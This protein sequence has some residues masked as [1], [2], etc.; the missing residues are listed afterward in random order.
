MP[1]LS[2][3]TAR[4]IK[5]ATGVALMMLTRGE[6]NSEKPLKN[7]ET[8]PVRTPASVPVT[9]PTEILITE[10]KTD[11]QNSSV[12]AN[13]Q[14]SETVSTGDGRIAESPTMADNACHMP[15]HISAIT[16]F[17]PADLS[18]CVN[19]EIITGHLSADYFCILFKENI[20]T[21]AESLLHF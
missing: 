6:R 8:A 17:L 1:V 3:I 14:S 9:N 13:L 7:D 4:I 19:I 11:N 16:I 5:D 21:A 15:S 10:N 18:V 20:I 2:H 12:T